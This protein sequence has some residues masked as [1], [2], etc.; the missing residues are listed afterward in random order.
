[1]QSLPARAM[2]LSAS[3]NWESTSFPVTGTVDEKF[4]ASAAA[5]VFYP[6]ANGYEPRGGGHVRVVIFEFGHFGAVEA[7]GEPAG[8]AAQEAFHGARQP[9]HDYELHPQLLPQPQKFAHVEAGIGAHH[10]QP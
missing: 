1:M 5:F 4:A 2:G 3:S 10:A 9:R 6:V 7:G 8:L